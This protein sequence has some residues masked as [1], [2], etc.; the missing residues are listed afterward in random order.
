M[1][2]YHLTA[3]SEPKEGTHVQ[4][5]ISVNQFIDNVLSAEEGE[6]DGS[7]YLAVTANCNLV[8]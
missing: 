6:G 4:Q 7:D 2:E 3:E 5:Q 8:T 1:R